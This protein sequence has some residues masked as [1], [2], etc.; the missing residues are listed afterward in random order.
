MV[1]VTMVHQETVTIL[2]LGMEMNIEL[3]SEGRRK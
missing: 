2:A 1:V 3:M